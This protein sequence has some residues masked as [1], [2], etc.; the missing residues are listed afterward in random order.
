M[1]ACT[2][3]YSMREQLPGLRALTLTVGH[4]AD[5]LAAEDVHRELDE[6]TQ[7]TQLSLNY[8]GMPVSSRT[9]CEAL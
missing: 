5:W 1:C 3:L 2:M 4:P 8:R 9:A 7:L 6:M